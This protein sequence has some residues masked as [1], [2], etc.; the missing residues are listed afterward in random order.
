MY[1]TGTISRLPELIAHHAGKRVL[2]V[3]DPGIRS[4]GHEDVVLHGLRTAN[5]EVTVFDEVHQNPTTDDV[6]V[7][8]KIA[9]EARVELIIGL[10]GGSS[11]DCAKGI[12]FLLTNGGEMKDYWGVGKATKPMLPLIAIPTTSGTGSEAQSFALIADA[13][14]HMKMACGDKK[15]AAEIAILDP[16]LTLTMP[17]SVTA[18]TGIDAITHAVET[19]VTTKRNPMSQ[20]FSREAW[21]L[22]SR[23]FAKVFDSPTD[24]S[25]RGDMQLG[26][27][28]AGFAIENSMLGAAHALANPLTAHF[29]TIHGV[30]VG[31]MLP[32]VIRFNQGVVGE[33][34]GELA[35]I[36]G[37][38][39][40]NDPEAPELL[41]RFL[42]NLFQLS[43][44]PT[45]LEA[46]K[47]NPQL[48]P[49][50]AAEAAQQW[51][52][53]FNPRPVNAESL[54]EV[55]TWA[56]NGAA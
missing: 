43:G 34:Y 53:T 14:T 21:R 36:S 16:Q 6:A 17:Q 40:A 4:A 19:Y 5:F 10:G 30:A 45:T 2:L 11:M 3:T 28:F 29:G 7:G 54:Q 26:A 27:H 24:L 44:T 50:M 13:Q 31:I 38:C 55:Y 32:Q 46:A 1:G 56:Y 25:A 49:T 42:E 41:A 23:G 35:E 22:L 39:E 15:A 52:G 51:T 48:F 18:V 9:A 12:N 20:L 33:L 47:V 8:L 37:L